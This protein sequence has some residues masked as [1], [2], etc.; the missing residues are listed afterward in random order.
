M[1]RIVDSN[2]SDNISGAALKSSRKAPSTVTA[3][4]KPGCILMNSNESS[5]KRGAGKSSRTAFSPSAV[6]ATKEA[7]ASWVAAPTRR[8]ARAEAAAVAEWSSVA[9]GRTPAAVAEPGS[10]ASRAYSGYPS[11][12]PGKISPT[13]EQRQGVH[14]DL[15][16]GA[17]AADNSH[18]ADQPSDLTVDDPCAS[19][20]RQYGERER[21]GDAEPEA[22]ACITEAILGIV[23]GVACW[24]KA[25]FAGVASR[26]CSS[27][28]SFSSAIYHIILLSSFLP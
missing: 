7:A 22:V 26:G 16:R 24:A 11:G 27:R 21:R 10:R 6:R 2:S 8:S 28:M 23:N 17:L 19:N 15:Q 14:R 5:S 1:T 25:V 12:G 4:T 18:Q 13:A 9:H 3:V 20:I